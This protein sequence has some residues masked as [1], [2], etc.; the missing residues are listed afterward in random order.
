MAAANCWYNRHC[1]VHFQGDR[2]FCCPMPN[3]RRRFA[4]EP[5]VKKHIDN[6]MNPHASKSRRINHMAN[7]ASNLAASNLSSV[8]GGLDGTKTPF[9]LT[10]DKQS[11]IIPRMGPAIKHELYFPQCYAPPFN[12]AFGAQQQAHGSS[13]GPSGNG[14]NGPTTPVPPAIPAPTVAQWHQHHAF[15]FREYVKGVTSVPP[16]APPNATTDEFIR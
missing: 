7:A 3:C 1:F 15:G 4:T 10:M 13:G 5:E 12:Q 11:N 6:H 14:G 2:P 9:Q 8:A 16:P